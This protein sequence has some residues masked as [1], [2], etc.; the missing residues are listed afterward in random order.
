MISYKIVRTKSYWIALGNNYLSR[1]FPYIVAEKLTTGE[2]DLFTVDNENDHDKRNQ[3]EIMAHC[4]IGKGI[5]ISGTPLLPPPEIGR[6]PVKFN[7]E[8]TSINEQG[9]DVWVGHYQY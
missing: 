1:I 6:I 3:F 4:P 5:I 9:Q 8:Y 7:H 2:Y